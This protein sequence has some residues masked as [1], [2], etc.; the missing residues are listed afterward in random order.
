MKATANK[1]ITLELSVRDAVWLR[2]VILESMLPVMA[3]FYRRLPVVFEDIYN[4]YKEGV[5]L[6][7]Q[8]FR[9]PQ[10]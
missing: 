4:K 8:K 10:R 5:K 1:A 9:S 3:E 7:T 2:F 6:C